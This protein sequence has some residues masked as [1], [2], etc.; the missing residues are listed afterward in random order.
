LPAVL[1]NSTCN[2]ARTPV[3]L[4]VERRA[5][6]NWQCK[7]R[8]RMSRSDGGKHRCGEVVAADAQ[9]VGFRRPR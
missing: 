7:G 1:G 3:P 4:L 8:P 6:P 2:V 5:R 9:D